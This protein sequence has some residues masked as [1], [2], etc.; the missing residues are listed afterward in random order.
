MPIEG[1]DS[2]WLLSKIDSK[3]KKLVTKN[4]ITTEIKVSSAK[5]IVMIGAGDI[6]VLI[7]DVV[8]ELKQ[9]Q[10]N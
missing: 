6:G 8:K 4:N 10:L 7:N 3:N 2:A 5:I 9:K 1:V